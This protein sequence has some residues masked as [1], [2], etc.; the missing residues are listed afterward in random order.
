MIYGLIFRKPTERAAMIKKTRFSSILFLT[1]ITLVAG[2]F[3]GNLFLI[4]NV[5]IDPRINTM[6]LLSV[7]TTLFGIVFISI[8]VDK[9]KE[10]DKIK[11]DLVLRNLD[12]LYQ[13]ID[14]LSLSIDNNRSNQSTI[15]SQLKGIGSQAVF[16]KTLTTNAKLCDGIHCNSFIEI[17][18]ILRFLTTNT[19]LRTSRTR[20]KNLRIEGDDFIYSEERVIEIDLEIEKFK[21]TINLEQMKIITI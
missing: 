1:I 2:F 12:D 16:Y 9:N 6:Q 8:I 3:L 5:S 14:K 17:H 21:N 20:D 19:E 13:K 11:K 15:K 18:R 10:I 7:L 4:P